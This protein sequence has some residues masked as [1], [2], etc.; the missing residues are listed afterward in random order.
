VKNSKVMMFV[1]MA[2]IEEALVAMA[3]LHS[4]QLNSRFYLPQSNLS[5]K[6]E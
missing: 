4:Y 6:G 1:M 3:H 5:S 2:S